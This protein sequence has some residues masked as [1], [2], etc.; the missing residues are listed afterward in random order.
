MLIFVDT[1][2]A[3]FASF[4]YRVIHSMWDG[5]YCGVRWVRFV[6]P[7][8]DRVLP[9]TELVGYS[10]RP[11]TQRKDTMLNLLMCSGQS[12]KVRR[13]HLHSSQQRAHTEPANFIGWT[14]TSYIVS[15]FCGRFAQEKRET[16]PDFCRTISWLLSCVISGCSGCRSVDDFAINHHIKVVVGCAT[17]AR[18]WLGSVI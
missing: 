4:V 9:K 18:F 3:L 10:G 6:S 12:S 2:G 16:Y 14:A 8:P 17:S 7:A 15:L 13:H 11:I 5:V 1:Q